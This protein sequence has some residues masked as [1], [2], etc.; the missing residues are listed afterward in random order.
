MKKFCE[1]G[2][3]IISFTNYDD[4]LI[5]WTEDGVYIVDKDGNKTQ[6]VDIPEEEGE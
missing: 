4:K 2:S 6:V 5:V 1:F 3:K